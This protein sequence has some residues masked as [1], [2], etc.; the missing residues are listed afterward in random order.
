MKHGLALLAA[1]LLLTTHSFTAQASLFDRGSGLIYDDV[2]EV[3]WLQNANLAATNTFGVSGIQ[4]NG[5]MDWATAQNWISAMNA[6]YYQGFNNWRLP[7]VKPINGVEFSYGWRYDEVSST[8]IQNIY[9]GTTFGPQSDWGYNIY[10]PNSEL[11]YMYHVNLGNSGRYDSMSSMTPQVIEYPGWTGVPDPTYDNTVCV[12]GWCNA[13]T[14]ITFSNLQSYAYWTGVSYPDANGGAA[15]SFYNYDGSQMAYA[16]DSP[17]FAWAVRDGDVSA[18]PL[19][20]AAWLFLSGMIGVLGLKRKR[21][22]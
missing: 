16:K 21:A 4:A 14:V 8:W 1:G 11:A 3:T 6:S 18:V 19:P 5:A 20:A 22:T 17:F 13:G 2:L 12:D 15:W 9:G 10:S 7:D